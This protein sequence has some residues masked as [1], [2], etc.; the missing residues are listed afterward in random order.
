MTST[1]TFDKSIPR[2]RY[3]PSRTQHDTYP[4][5]ASKKYQVNT[6]IDWSLETLLIPKHSQA[7]ISRKWITLILAAIVLGYTTA[8]IQLMSINLNDAKMGICFTKSN[9][10]S[11]LNPY[12]TC[13]DNDWYNWSRILFKVSGE[14][15][16]L[17][18]LPIYI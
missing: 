18:N 14:G 6:F 15:S 12:S 9:M 13:P 16:I 7:H 17:I 11:L 10:W 1:Y 4:A 8:F 2:L 3:N 5:T